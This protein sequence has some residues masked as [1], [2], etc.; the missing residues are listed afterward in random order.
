MRLGLLEWNYLVGN[1]QLR[2]RFWERWQFPHILCRQTDQHWCVR[3]ACKGRMATPRSS[4]IGYLG[5]IPLQNCSGLRVNVVDLYILALQFFKCSLSPVE[6]TLPHTV[7]HSQY[8]Q[9]TYIESRSW[10]FSIH[11][12]TLY[13]ELASILKL[14]TLGTLHWLWLV[15]FRIL[16]LWWTFS[17]DL[18]GLS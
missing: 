6:H 11:Y 2:Y 3:R 4:E 13:P 1:M 14:P 15:S 9:V 16:P 18:T 17:L 5:I 10:I 8:P 7:S 12:Y